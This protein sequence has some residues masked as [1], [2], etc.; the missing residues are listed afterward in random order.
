MTTP[1][2]PSIQRLAPFAAAAAGVGFLALMDAFMKEAAL[3]AGAYSATVLR[4]LIGAAIAAP[5]WLVQRKAWPDRGTLKLHIERGVISAFMALGFFYA[6]TTMPLAEAIA[7]SFVAPIIALYLAYVFLGEEI[8]REAIIASVLGFGGTIVIV[9]GQLGLGRTDKA[10]VSSD[11]YYGLAAMGVSALLYAYNFIVIRKQSQRAGPAE[12]AT[13]H[14]GVSFLLLALFAPFFW[15]TPGTQALLSVTAAG[16][17]TVAGSMA[18]AWA[19]ARAE[20]QALVPIEYSGF[21]WASLFGWLFFREEV[22]L[23]T[24][25]GVALIV[26]G[27]WIAARSQKSEPAPSTKRAEAV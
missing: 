16:A 24:M 10:A 2:T 18:I 11:Y 12:I 22:T 21:L 5:I 14:S 4:A 3:A 26:A 6:I 20:T 8:R 15:S 9:G 7:I 25:I 23:P 1:A 27:C 17:L 13:F 19:Y